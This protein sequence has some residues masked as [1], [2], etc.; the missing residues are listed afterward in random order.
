MECTHSADVSTIGS[1]GKNF[2]TDFDG[3]DD[4]IAL[5]GVKFDYGKTR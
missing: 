3:N 2:A 5:V 4:P 1:Y